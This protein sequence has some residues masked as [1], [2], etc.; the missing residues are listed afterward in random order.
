MEVKMSP[1]IKDTLRQ[2]VN[3]LKKDA[4]NGKDFTKK[5]IRTN[6]IGS[7]F[8][9]YKIS[10]HTLLTLQFTNN[11]QSKKEIGRTISFTIVSKIIK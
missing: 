8:A 2:K 1:R 11:E 7:V 4:E 10:I 3:I 5:S 6:K 9:E